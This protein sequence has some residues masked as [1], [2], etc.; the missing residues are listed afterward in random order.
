V[1]LLFS[2]ELDSLSAV[3]PTH[4]LFSPAVTLAR[5]SLPGPGFREVVLDLGENLRPR[6][7]YTLTVQQ[8][9]DCA[10]NTLDPAL[11][12]SVVLPEPAVAGEVV[13]NEVLFN[14]LPGGVDFVELVNRSAKFIELKNWQL[15]EGNPDAPSG[16]TTITGESLLLAPQQYLV[17]TTRPD[18]I[19]QHYIHSPP[20]AFL[21]MP[22]FPA[23]AD[24]AG[25]VLL[26]NADGS[27][28][29]RL[30]YHQD[31]HFALLDDRNG[32]SLE[33][34]RLAGDSSRANWHSA[35]STAGFATPGSRNSQ[36]Y[37]AATGARVFTIEPAA[38]TPDGDGDR[39][40]A[41]IN[42]QAAANGY[43]A[44]ITVYDAGGREI[45]RLVK[46]QLLATRGFFQWDGLTE[47][48][49]KAPLG[50]YILFIEMF[51]IGGPVRIYKETVALGA[52]F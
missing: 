9:R 51:K 41:T 28:I 39:D 32:V 21:A 31:M 7:I 35:A 20:D 46:N 22:G 24:E 2:E 42:Y 23:Y 48:G 25:T 27:L 5:V 47:R 50:Y 11:A 6:Q 13:I 49:Q 29:D 3:D 19:R 8:L 14:P 33:R 12:V 26:R 1:R 40:F 43:L 45:R 10:G 37:E 4:F 38:F 15:A 18:I 30:D 17:L 34:I 16:L 44:S 36:H 52:R